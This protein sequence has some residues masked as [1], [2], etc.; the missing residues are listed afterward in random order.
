VWIGSGAAAA[1]I[2]A[3]VLV[4]VLVVFNGDNEDVADV[5]TTLPAATTLVTQPGDP[6][7]TSALPPATATSVANGGNN[8]GEAKEVEKVVRKFF[9]A[10]EDQD[11]STFI[12]LMDPALLGALPQGEGRDAALAAIGASLAGLGKMKF[13]GLEFKVDIT[14]PTT[15]S[16]TLTAGKATITDAS[17]NKTT[18]DVKDAEGSAAMEM[19]KVDGKWYIA[20]SAFM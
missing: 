1:V 4:L 9:Q 6:T 16:V 17:G 2:I 11:W 15:A 3:V 13:E 20:T 10:M 8:K 5:S 19:K 14:S 18:E 7:G 12:D